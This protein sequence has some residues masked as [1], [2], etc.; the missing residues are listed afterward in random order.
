MV[1]EFCSS[2]S[3]IELI[4]GCMKMES[5]NYNPLATRDDGTCEEPKK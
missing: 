2:C 5:I 4:Y 3:C 1:G